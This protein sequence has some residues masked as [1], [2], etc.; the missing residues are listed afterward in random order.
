VFRRRL[1]PAICNRDL[2]AARRMEAKTIGGNLEMYPEQDASQV[3]H[4]LLA[5]TSVLLPRGLAILNPRPHL[6]AVGRKLDH[7]RVC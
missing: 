1:S 7:V 6:V 4:S 2:S 3:A 5:R